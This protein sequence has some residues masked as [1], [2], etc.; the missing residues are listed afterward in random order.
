MWLRQTRR[1]RRR[2]GRR[3]RRRKPWRRRRC[4]CPL[5]RMRPDRRGRLRAT[6]TLSWQRQRRQRQRR[7]RPTPRTS[8]PRQTRTAAAVAAETEAVTEGCGFF[9]RRSF[10]KHGCGNS[11]NTFEIQNGLNV[12]VKP[13]CF[14]LFFFQTPW[15]IQHVSHHGAPLENKSGA[16]IELCFAFESHFA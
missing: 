3:V 2:C 12:V 11:S 5:R 14:P 16:I 9:V 6:Q 15:S 13:D 10:E 7:R 4:G 1:R 8:L